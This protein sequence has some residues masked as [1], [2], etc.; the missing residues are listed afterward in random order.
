MCHNI[1]ANAVI[2][3]AQEAM[4]QPAA[5]TVAETT[6]TEGAGGPGRARPRMTTDDEMSQR[7]EQSVTDDTHSRNRLVEAARKAHL[8]K[9]EAAERTSPTTPASTR[10]MQLGGNPDM[11]QPASRP[12]PLPGKDAGQGPDRQDEDEGHKR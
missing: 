4:K 9:T 6:G 10:R 12:R 3:D 11:P 2:K 8:P 5:R 7:G 1:N